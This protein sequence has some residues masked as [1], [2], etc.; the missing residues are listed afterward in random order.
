MNLYTNNVEIK[1]S[2]LDYDW[3]ISSTDGW[4]R[5]FVRVPQYFD[6]GNIFTHGGIVYFQPTLPNGDGKKECSYWMGWEYN[7]ENRP[8]KDRE[9]I[10][11]CEKVINQVRGIISGAGNLFYVAD[12]NR[13]TLSISKNLNYIKGL[14]AM[15]NH[16]YGNSLRIYQT[17]TGY[18]DSSVLLYLYKWDDGYKEVKCYF[19]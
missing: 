13:H 18:W 16:S 3:F 1:G 12:E 7:D 10:A 8:W 11:H 17:P 9:I 14:A 5:A 4:I 19:D 6:Y 2:Y 15:A